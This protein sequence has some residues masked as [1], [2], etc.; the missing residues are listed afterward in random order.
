MTHLA[1][2]YILDN[3][4]SSCSKGRT[5]AR[6]VVKLE[7]ETKADALAKLDTDAYEFKEWFNER[8]Y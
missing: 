3:A 7:G 5:G 6:L 2:C 4:P 8:V 1:L